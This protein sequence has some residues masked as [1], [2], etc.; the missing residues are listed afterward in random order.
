MELEGAGAHDGGVHPESPVDA[1]E[2]GAGVEVSTE[3]R[4]QGKHKRILRE[5]EEEQSEGA[6]EE[7]SLTAAPG[8]GRE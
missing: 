2:V 5:R 4:D 8:A 3:C 6:A 7:A 1:K